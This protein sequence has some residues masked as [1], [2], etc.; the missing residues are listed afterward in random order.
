MFNAM[1]RQLFILLA[2]LLSGASVR[3]IDCPPD[4]C[5]RV[6]FAN[7][8]SHLDALVIWAALPGA[9]R[10]RTRMVAARDYWEAGPIRRY[11]AQK[12]FNALLI[13][14]ENI[15]I[16]NTPVKVI[17]DGM[18]DRYSIIIFPEGGRSDD[19][20]GE[21]GPFKSGLY[22]IAKKR[23]DLELIPVCLHNMNRILPRGRTLPVPMLARVT[24]GPPMWLE[25]GENRDEFLDRAREAILKLAGKQDE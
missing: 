17:L 23:P 13:D 15:S 14:R 22:H 20:E 18:E 6:Y 11:I 5:Q 9:I 19:E 7:H 3:W 2:R 4:I 1:I 8:T 10:E 25:E 12:L 16:R 24:F 21:I